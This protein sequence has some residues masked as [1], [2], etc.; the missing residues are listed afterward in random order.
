MAAYRRPREAEFA[1]LGMSWRPSWCWSTFIQVTRVNSH[2]G[3]DIDDG[4]I[5]T[6]LVIIIINIRP[7][8]MRVY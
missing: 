1:N 6:A 4:T 7:T 2:N 8:C 3:F 5:N